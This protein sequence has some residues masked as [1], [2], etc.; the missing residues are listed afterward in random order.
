MASK[1][2]CPSMQFFERKLFLWPVTGAIS[3]VLISVNLFY[4]PALTLE[5]GIA[6]WFADMALVL[7]LSAHPTT[8]RVGGFVSGLLLAVPC[9]VREPPLQRG[10]LMCCMAFPFAIAA[11][12]LLGPPA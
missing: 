11:L 2:Q 8:A 4:R 12:P 3:S 10:L 7:L 6:A 9:F 1:C 5:L